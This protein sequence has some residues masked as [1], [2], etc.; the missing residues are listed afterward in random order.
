M[1]PLYNG[2]KIL[3][4][5]LPDRFK[6]LQFLLLFQELRTL[7]CRNCGL[8]RIN[9]QL[10]HLLPYLTHLD[11]GYNAI[12][13][14][15][16]DEFQDLHRLHT[17]KLDGNMFPVI[18]ENTF[19]HQQQLK[20]LNLARNRIAKLP[21]TALA[22]LT[23]LLELDLGYN[24]LYK[25][26]QLAFTHVASSLEKLSL[27]G[28]NLK[29]E[30]VKLVMDTVSNVVELGVAHMKLQQVEKGFFPDRI[31]SL[32]LSGNNLTMLDAAVLP[33]QLKR[34]DLSHNNL[35]SLNKVSVVLLES[36]EY[37]NLVGNPWRCDQCHISDLLPSPLSRN[38]SCAF[39][40]SLLGQSLTGLTVEEIPLCGTELREQDL[41]SPSQGLF[42]GL[43]CI[44]SFGFFSVVFVV[45]SCVKRH[46]TSALQR[47]KRTAESTENHL[48]SKSDITFQFPLDLMAVSTIDDMKKDRMV[49]GSVVTGL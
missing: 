46:Q 27:S 10:Y 15:Y 14:L 32:D 49:N 6:K 11:L 20:H 26:E 28:N 34:L 16:Y 19:V 13:Y 18:L 48:S 30:G 37:V 4:A 24:K 29:P 45:Y 42:I 8:Q 5:P 44:L 23:S 43:L 12:Q 36:L 7:E 38:I 33:K 40:T 2:C 9:T 35:K 3:N 31:T 1:S 39:P 41:K 47:E 21:N 25:V 17:L 22:N